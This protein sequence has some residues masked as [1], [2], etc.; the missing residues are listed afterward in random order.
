MSMGML[1]LSPP[2]N[3]YDPAYFNS[4]DPKKLPL[5]GVTLSPPLLVSYPG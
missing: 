3:A 5:V 1:P 2:A 4:T